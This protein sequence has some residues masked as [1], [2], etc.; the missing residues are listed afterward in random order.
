M[1]LLRLLNAQRTELLPVE[2]RGIT[3]RNTGDLIDEAAWVVIC[4]AIMNTDEFI[5]RE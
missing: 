1:I 3:G 5:T 2:A 4:R